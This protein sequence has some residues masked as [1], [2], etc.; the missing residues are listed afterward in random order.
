MCYKFIPPAAKEKKRELKAQTKVLP[1]GI[2]SKVRSNR[3]EDM[4]YFVSYYKGKFAG[5]KFIEFKK[6]VHVDMR[7]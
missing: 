7:I 3:D 1:G 5:M 4:S 6:W 2:I